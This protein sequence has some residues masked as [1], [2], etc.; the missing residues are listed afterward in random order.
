MYTLLITARWLSNI[1]VKWEFVR[2]NHTTFKGR[3]SVRDAKH[4]GGGGY[5]RSVVGELVEC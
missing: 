2:R 4:K 5:A 1:N 3:I